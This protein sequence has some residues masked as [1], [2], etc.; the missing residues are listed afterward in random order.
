MIRE[1][2]DSGEVADSNLDDFESELQKRGE[3]PLNWDKA[4]PSRAVPQGKAGEGSPPENLS[5][6]KRPD[7]SVSNV[8][9]LPKRP[10]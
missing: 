6:R 10:K 3:V 5:A 4:G 9:P 2:A 1:L 7:H 8:I